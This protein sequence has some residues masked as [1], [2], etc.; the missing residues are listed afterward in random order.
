MV[1]TTPILARVDAALPQSALPPAGG[2]LVQIVTFP[3]ADG[4][5]QQSGD[6]KAIA[7]EYLARLPG[8]AETFEPGSS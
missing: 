1:L 3:P 8:L 5:P 4:R 2:S 6:P 7:R